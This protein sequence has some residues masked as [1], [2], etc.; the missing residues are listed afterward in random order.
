MIKNS[1][2]IFKNYY[3]DEASSVLSLEYAY[4]YG[5]SFTEI[6][7]FPQAKKKLSPDERGAL[8]RCFKQL[9]LAA[10]ISYYKAYCSPHII[11]ETQRLCPAEAK[12][13]NKLYLHGLGEFA[14][15]NDLDL[16]EVIKF[17]IEEPKDYPAHNLEL[18]AGHIVPIGGGKDSIVSLEA[19]K[20]AGKNIKLFAVKPNRPI[21]EVMDKSHVKERILIER[22]LDPKLFELNHKDAMNGHVPITGILSFIMAA[23]SIL[24]GFDTAVMSNEKSANEGNM[25]QNG[26]DINHQYSKSLEFE[27]DFA[28]FMHHHV[29]ESFRYFSLLRPLSEIGIAALFS[30]YPQ[31]FD[32]FK[33]CNRN[34]HISEKVREYGWCCKCPKCQFVF[35]A[36]APFMEKSRLLEIFGQNL[37]D[38]MS[39]ENGFRELLGLKGHKPFECV[40]EIEECRFIISS[41][42]LMPD[43]KNDILIL[44]LSQELPPI[45]LPRH[46][47]YKAALTMSEDHILIPEYWDILQG[48]ID[49]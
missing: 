8:D 37:L 48:L 43:W 36:L 33:S 44:K 26:L 30:C 32:V 18:T 42:A 17:P 16:R 40:G 29:L 38:D 25:T 2:F 10:G 19:L 4:A 27:E 28:N 41:L 35:L 21:T 13:F 34:F 45:G 23:S 20:L 11:I 1:S 3:Y 46:A 15:K 7:T 6:I 24:Y 12:F 14:V 47:L 22:Q 9:H 5:E 31:Y 39:Q 49:V